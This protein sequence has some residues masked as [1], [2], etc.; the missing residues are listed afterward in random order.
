MNADKIILLDNGRVIAEGT[1]DQLVKESDFYRE[2]CAS[3]QIRA[4]AA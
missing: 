3:Q 1:H 4:G 2:I